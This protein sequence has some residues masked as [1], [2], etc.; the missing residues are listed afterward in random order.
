MNRE[1]IAHLRHGLVPAVPVPFASDGLIDDISLGRYAKWM[2]SQAV[3]GVA[4]WAH[5]GRG[6]YLTHSQREQVLLAWRE[7]MPK[8]LI[9]AGAGGSIDAKDDAAFFESARMMASHAKSLGADTI[10][11]YAPARFRDRDPAKRDSLILRYHS[12]L[13]EVGLPM[14]LFYLYEAAGGISYSADLLKQLLLIDNVIGIKIATLDSVMTF[15]DVSAHCKRVAPEK[16][17]ITGEDRFLGYSLMC[18]A[19]AALIGMGAAYTQ[20]QSD[21]LQSYFASDL[22]RFHR[23]SQQIDVLA[24]A[25]FVKPMEGYIARMSFILSK[26]GHFDS[27]SFCDPW[28]PAL[29]TSELQEL[30]RVIATLK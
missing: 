24:Q 18:S 26:Q 30:D 10:L 1:L 17:V 7:A 8:A 25:T 15:Q 2:S 16:L 12:V 5:T 9:I 3:A 11:C 6:L 27:E 13:A 21:L 28:G 19:D 22:D 14:I 29:N 20:I 23:L 4:V